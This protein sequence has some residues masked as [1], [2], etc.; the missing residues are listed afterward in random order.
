LSFFRKSVKEIQVSSKSDKITGILY[1]DVSIFVTTYRWI[2]YIIRNI[3]D[4]SCRENQNT[5]FMS[6]NSPPPPLFRKSAAHLLTDQRFC[7]PLLN[8]CFALLH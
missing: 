8:M 3:S 4:K 2:L 7:W 1:E 5:H 6:H